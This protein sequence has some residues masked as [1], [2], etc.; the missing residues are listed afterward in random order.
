MPDRR[1]GFEGAAGAA[2]A[3]FAV[4]GNELRME[5]LWALWES[6]EAVMPFAELRRQVAPED[7]GNFNYHLGKLTDHFVR[8]TDEGY[9]LRV[10]GE[11]VIRAVLTGTITDDSTLAPAEIDEECAYC[12][13]PVEMCYEE[14]FISVRCTSCGGVVDREYLP[15]TYMRYGFPPAGLVDRSREEA[16]DAAH[17]LYDSKVTPMMRGVCP[18]CAGRVSTNFLVCDDHAEAE[19]GLCQNCQT[20][21]AVWVVY[22][23]RHCQYARQSALWFAVVNHPAA[24]AFLHEHGLTESIPF[25]KLTGDNGRFIRE[26]TSS[27][28]DTDPYRFRVTIPVDEDALVVSLDADLAVTA[29]DRRSTAG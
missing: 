23:C 2:A 17:V 5:I 19:S 26:I 16:V 9:S 25:R 8:K 14:D 6:S 7:T 3:A 12:G 21:Y 1:E 10:A 24:V 15:G 27:V 22:E 18:E 28:V 11:H 20:R 29:I 13:S 4:L